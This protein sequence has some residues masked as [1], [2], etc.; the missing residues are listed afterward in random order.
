VVISGVVTYLNRSALPPVAVIE[1]QLQDVTIADAPSTV[2]ASQRQVAGGRQ[3]PIPFELAY[4]PNQIQEGRIYALSV[5]IT[6]DGALRYINTTLQR[7]LNDGAPAT[8]IEVVVQ[9]V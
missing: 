4:N 3:V 5:R 6:I 9:P 7:V 2:L 8:D 1:V